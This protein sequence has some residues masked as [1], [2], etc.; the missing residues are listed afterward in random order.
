MSSTIDKLLISA[1]VAG[2][3]IAALANLRAVQRKM[4]A[5]GIDPHSLTTAQT[6]AQTTSVNTGYNSRL[7]DRVS[8]LQRALTIERRTAEEALFTIT[9][10]VPG[11]RY[12]AN[13][14]WTGDE[15]EA[16]ER[17]KRRFEKERKRAWAWYHET[18]DEI[19]DL[20]DRLSQIAKLA[21]NNDG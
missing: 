10:I 3:D 17:R 11:P 8:K 6:T 18:N 20:K 15:V 9:G 13:R 2:D 16:A 12:D 1:L 7:H 4:N 14:N 21:A 5:E 19:A